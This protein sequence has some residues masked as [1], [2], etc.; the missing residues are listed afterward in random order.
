VK[1][2]FFA[3]GEAEQVER[4]SDDGEHDG[5]SRQ[6]S[7]KLLRLGFVVC[8]LRSDHQYEDEGADDRSHCAPDAKTGTLHGVL[9][10]RGS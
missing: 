3:A 5:H 10:H 1:D 7:L 4:V 9:R 2:L 8:D 6:K